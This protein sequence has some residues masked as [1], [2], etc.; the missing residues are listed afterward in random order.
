[1]LQIENWRQEAATN[2]QKYLDQIDENYTK[3]KYVTYNARNGSPLSGKGLKG[4]ASQVGFC[5]I[6]HQFHNLEHT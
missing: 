1:M 4:Y 2:H 5:R 3:T 6:Y